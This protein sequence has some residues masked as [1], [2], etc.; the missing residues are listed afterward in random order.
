[1]NEL[2]LVIKRF[3]YED[4]QMVVTKLDNTLFQL[5]PPQPV[6]DYESHSDPDIVPYSENPVISNLSLAFFP[7]D[8]RICAVSQSRLSADHAVGWL[9]LSLSPCLYW[10]HKRE[11]IKDFKHVC[12]AL[13]LTAM[14][15][16]YVFPF[17]FAPSS[18]CFW[19]QMPQVNLMGITIK[20]RAEIEKEVSRV[21]NA[22]LL[23]AQNAKRTVLR[24]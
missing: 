18:S 21:C 5:P 2:V 22:L 13:S 14:F 1:M 8:W 9:W 23:V 4:F 11:R 7:A 24:L 10:H 6:V 3:K 19:F 16:V 15:L 20:S 17:S 12:L